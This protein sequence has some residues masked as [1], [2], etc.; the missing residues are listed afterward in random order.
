VIDHVEVAPGRGTVIRFG[1]LVAWAGPSATPALVSF[2][3]QSLA[4]LG[5]SPRGGQQMAE[6]LAGVLSERDPEPTVPFAVA[7]PDGGVWVALLH[8]PVQAWDGNDWLVPDPVRGWIRGVVRPGPALAVNGAGA[9]TPEVSPDSLWDLEAGIVPGSGFV[10]FPARAGVPS[11][12]ARREAPSPPIEE[13]RAPLTVDSDETASLKTDPDDSVGDETVTYDVFA[14]DDPS[15][16]ETAVQALIRDDEA[17]TAAETLAVVTENAT[18]TMSTVGVPVDAAEPVSMPSGPIDLRRTDDLP[19]KW[20]RT[21]LPIGRGP[22]GPVAGAPVVAGVLCER[23][24]VNKP[25]TEACIKCATPIPADVAYTM[26]GSRPPLGCLVSDDASVFRL[27]RAYLVG[28][29]PAQDAT[30]SGGLA[31]P[32]LLP[33]EEVAASHAEIR[34]QDWDVIVIDRAGATH[35]LEPNT[36]DWVRLRA[37]EPR[38]LIPGAHIA[39]GQRTLTYLTPWV[40]RTTDA[41]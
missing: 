18:V 6:H 41:G 3:A 29:D 30:V 23:G 16:D 36:T 39:I 25:G 35:V 5:P 12:A 13:G 17:P 26:S 21:P 19:F 37:Y 40:R 9:P 34:L 15:G 2:L 7:G 1:H 10:M 32:L 27:D 8:G 22:D 24:H 14:D 20:G 4:N 28:S 33:G 11:E 38:P 31:E